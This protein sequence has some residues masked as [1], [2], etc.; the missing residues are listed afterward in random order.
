MF[1]ASRAFPLAGFLA[2][3]LVVAFVGTAAAYV[4][5]G[6]D[7]SPEDIHAAGHRAARYRDPVDDR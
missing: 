2:A 5:T 3:V 1:H 7:G 6:T 4:V